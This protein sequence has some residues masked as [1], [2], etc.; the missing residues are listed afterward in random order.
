M[1]NRLTDGMLVAEFLA[2]Q[3]HNNGR[4]TVT[5]EDSKTA[6]V[7]LSNS[8]ASQPAHFAEAVE[9]L[10]FVNHPLFAVADGFKH[11]TQGL[12]LLQ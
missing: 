2:G 10:L 12:V 11:L 4:A 8:L 6:L 7:F 3:I 5:N 9:F 1:V